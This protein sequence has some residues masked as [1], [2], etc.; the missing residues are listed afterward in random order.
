MNQISC[1]AYAKINLTLDVGQRRPD[2]YHDIRSIM[3]T[4][5]LH[6]TLTVTAPDRPGI[7]LEVVGEEATGVP[8]DET[9]LVHK[10]AVRVQKIAAARELLPGNQSGLHILLHKRIPS[11]A[12]LGGGSSDAA[13]ALAAVS[14]LLGLT[15]SPARLREIAA[16]LGADVPFF[17]TGGT[18]LAEGLGERITPL[19]PLAA[20][21]P[22]VLVKPNAGVST[23]AAYAA[24]DAVMGRE[25]GGATQRRLLG[26][27][28]FSND[29]EAVILPA[30]PEVAA[31]YAALSQT[32][33]GGESFKPLLC[34]SGSALFLRASSPAAAEQ[35]AARI[36]AAEVGK[37]WVT[38]TIGARGDK[39][40]W[41]Q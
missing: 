10:A 11:Q 19:A 23:A 12:G 1:S 16:A 24:L 18:A 7:H 28:V 30:Y 39:E 2:G 29:F 21:W 26:Q 5:A 36:T 14:S 13:A 3:Q 40:S 22:L 25:A 17:L 34:G 35:I 15:L 38:Q 6:D 41:T 32:A 4:I 8:S 31:A 20:D 27:Q 33:E 9:N 37:V